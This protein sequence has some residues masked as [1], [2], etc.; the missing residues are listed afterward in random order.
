[1]SS[2]VQKKAWAVLS[3]FLLAVFYGATLAAADVDPPPA[4]G[5]GTAPGHHL[6]NAHMTWKSWYVLFAICV[7]LV[8]LISGVADS[9]C[10]MIAVSSSCYLLGIITTKELFNGMANEG[11]LAI[12][13]LFVIVTPMSELP[14]MKSLIRL[15]FRSVKAGGSMRWALFNIC[16][17][18]MLFSSLLE[19]IPQVSMMTSV[20]RDICDD[21]KL[22]P[23]QLLLPMDYSV[24]I[25]NYAIIGATNNLVI[26]GLMVKFGMPEMKFF[27]LAK[28]NG[29]MSIVC[30]LYLVFFP[31][32]LLPRNK[33]GLLKMH[34]VEK[35]IHNIT[36][37][38]LPESN[39]IGTRANEVGGHF[40]GDN[41]Q[42]S[43]RFVSMSR[44]G[45]PTTP[46]TVIQSGDVLT[47]FGGAEVILASLEI[48]GLKCLDSIQRPCDFTGSR[49]DGSGS[50]L[51]KSDASFRVSITASPTEMKSV[52]GQE[53]GKTA[54][55]KSPAET[56]D[57][58]K[59]LKDSERHQTQP[60][61]KSK[62][63]VVHDD[64]AESTSSNTQST[65][66]AA[67]GGDGAQQAPKPTEAMNLESAEQLKNAN[68][69]LIDLSQSVAFNRVPDRSL[70]EVIL[71]ADSSWLGRLATDNEI[72][73]GYTA[74]VVGVKVHGK[75]FDRADM[76][77]RPLEAGNTV[78]L[79]APSYF[80]EEHGNEFAL[81]TK[82]GDMRQKVLHSQFFRFPRWSPIGRFVCVDRNH[83]YVRVPTWWPYWSV[84][85]FFGIVIGALLG[86]PLAGCCIIAVCFVVAMGVVSAKE[87]LHY[88]DWH[89]FVFVAFSFG[90]GMSVDRSGLA[91]VVGKLVTQAN[92]T[93]FP[94]L[95]LISF[96]TIILANVVNN[97]T[98]AQVMFPVVFAI[99][100]AQDLDPLPGVMVMASTSVVALATPYGYAS[101]M[102]VMEPGGYTPTDFVRFGIPLSIIVAV[103]VPLTAWL[104]Y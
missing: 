5:N 66:E 11:V 60:Q 48:L 76:E 4:S 36:V 55:A 28:I 20:I 24:L 54:P 91:A 61:D 42:A 86:I 1:M 30:L 13:M 41:G 37:K 93:G 40:P 99:Y 56:P 101:N 104:V 84:V 83:K 12:L 27:E 87:A 18:S 7:M 85:A 10:V 94:L 69:A 8:V 31:H 97:K 98:A 58:S 79:F 19:N 35:A 17:S 68:N 100:K 52:K 50:P 22:A 102:M 63:G 53:D 62:N 45:E 70:F 9:M 59:L 16:F 46:E 74:S 72:A 75:P 44:A 43:C 51:L 77:H 80:Q 82:L 2:S 21:L 14:L 29:P 65:A 88:I 89:V 90:I 81:V 23:S 6:A 49:V 3:L 39:L 38:V 71:S 32:F 34:K 92:V 73:L 15:C 57:S 95:L 47:V 26:S 67:E 103:L 78:L 25:G 64:N 33:G 96:L